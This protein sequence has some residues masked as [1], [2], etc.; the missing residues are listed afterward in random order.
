MTLWELVFLNFMLALA[1]PTL[2]R[3]DAVLLAVLGDRV[4]H[5]LNLRFIEHATRL[6]LLQLEDPILHDRMTRARDQITSR[7]PAVAS[8]L[9]C[10]QEFLTLL[11]FSST[12]ATVSPLMLGLLFTAVVPSIWGDAHYSSLSYSV[13]VSRTSARRMLDYLVR[14][15]TSSDAAKEVRLFGL[16]AYLA[17]RFRE[18]SREIIA[19]HREMAIRAAIGGS[20]LGVFAVAGYYA[21]YAGALIKVLSGGISIGTFAFA[22]G[23]FARCQSSIERLSSSVTRIAESSLFLT[24]LFAFLSVQPM[25]RTASANLSVPRPISA[26]LEFRNVSFVYPGS[27]AIALKNVSFRIGPD[28]TVAFIG[29]N[30]SGKTTLVKLI[31]RLYD[32]S[33]GQILLDGID[34]RDYAVEDLRRQVS[35]IFQDFARYD[36][37]VTDNIRVGDVELNNYCDRLRTAARESGAAEFIERLPRRYDQMLGRRFED[38]LD[39]SGGQW[40]RIALARSCFR[41]AQ[42]GILDEPGS[43]LDAFAEYE[44]FQNYLESKGHRMIVLISHR[45][46]TVRMADSI[47][48]FSNGELRERGTHAELC[49]LAGEYA[50]LFEMQASGYR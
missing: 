14:L 36:M 40:Q 7:I 5:R 4:S 8:S 20:L 43:S 18:I 27:N 30:G 29:R 35:V 16:G 19:E 12:F 11:A 2:G 49:A 32:P 1:N 15:A 45:L 28:Q 25:I 44:L 23:G 41:E 42:I 46:S 24:D 3:V 22:V 48:V 31:T 47:F 39:I 26:G 17:S 21:A 33:A 37:S 13:A 6:D 34:L 10:M 50:E 38:G 9:N